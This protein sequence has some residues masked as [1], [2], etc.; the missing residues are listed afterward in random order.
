MSRLAELEERWDLF[1]SVT[2]LLSHAFSV[3]VFFPRPRNTHGLLSHERTIFQVQH[4]PPRASFDQ[5]RVH[6]VHG[7]LP[8]QH[9]C[10]TRCGHPSG[11]FAT[12]RY[13]SCS[14]CLRHG[15]RPRRLSAVHKRTL[16]GAASLKHRGSSPGMPFTHVQR[17]MALGEL[18]SRATSRVVIVRA[19]LQFAVISCLARTHLDRSL[20]ISLATTSF[21]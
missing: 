10:W 5:Q 17:A 12:S 13:W 4:P 15:R 8:I 7:S 20:P 19:P 14:R 21:C 11:P 16:R 3:H 9:C 1:T 18:T 6:R 2:C